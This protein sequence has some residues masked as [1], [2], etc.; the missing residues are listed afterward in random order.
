MAAIPPFGTYCSTSAA[1]R[2]RS[3][4][5]PW[6]RLDGAGHWSW[7]A[8][9]RCR[10]AHLHP[11]TCWTTFTGTMGQIRLQGT[12]RWPCW[13]ALCQGAKRGLSYRPRQGPER[14]RCP[15]GP[16]LR[17]GKERRSWRHN[18]GRIGLR[19]RL[20][21]GARG[22]VRPAAEPRDRPLHLSDLGRRRPPQAVTHGDRGRLASRPRRARVVSLCPMIRIRWGALIQRRSREGA[23]PP[24][25]G[26]RCPGT[27]TAPCGGTAY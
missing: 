1:N 3:S 2:P 9:K 11:G 27:S 10:P 16:V 20:L 23:P 17:E 26:R 13:P 7:R 18:V 15:R 6:S 5:C 21:R 24:T 22:Q 25:P 12:E 19:R 4:V 8:G 14:L